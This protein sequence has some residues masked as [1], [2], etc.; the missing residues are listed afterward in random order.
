MTGELPMVETSRTIQGKSS[1]VVLSQTQCYTA[2]DWQ[3]LDSKN[4]R[5]D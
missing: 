5:F 2:T 1:D 4:H 3:C